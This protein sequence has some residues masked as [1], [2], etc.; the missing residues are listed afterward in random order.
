[1]PPAAF[2]EGTHQPVSPRLRGIARKL[3]RNSTDAEKLLWELLRNRRFAAF[4]FR[5]QV[6]VGPFVADFA[7]FDAMLIVELDG[8]QHFESQRDAARDS[9]LSRRG[10]HILRI[11]NNDLAAPDIVLDAIWHALH[12]ST[13]Q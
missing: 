9:E 10:F 2:H 1:M 7:C 11:W 12:R 3:R 13:L 6:P 8:S 4:K 5:R